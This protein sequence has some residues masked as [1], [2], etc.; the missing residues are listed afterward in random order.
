MFTDGSISD[1]PRGEGGYAAIILTDDGFIDLV[2]GYNSSTTNN[3]MEMLAVLWG[4]KHLY[5]EGV[6][7]E[8][9]VY[10]DSE[11]VVKGM[12]HW[13]Y[14]WRKK[15]TLDQK[16]NNDLWK[17]MLKAMHLMK[18]VVRWVK[19]HNG[20]KYNELADK[21]ANMARLQQDDEIEELKNNLN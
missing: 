17:Q 6:D 12:N 13:V 19:A 8:V 7:E 20:N 2:Y 3:R 21:V 1:N 16:A 4:L 10:S 18:P 9:F 14:G 5:N 15:G 11:Y